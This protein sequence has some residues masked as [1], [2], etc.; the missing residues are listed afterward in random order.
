MR[1]SRAG[2]LLG[3]G[4][5]A[6]GQRG[7]CLSAET[8]TGSINPVDELRQETKLVEQSLPVDSSGG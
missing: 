5:L 7:H 2:H 6:E 8:S 1:S 4:D 3:V